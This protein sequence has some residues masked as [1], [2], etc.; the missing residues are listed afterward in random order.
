MA[1]KSVSVIFDEDLLEKVDEKRKEKKISRNW[2]ID[3]L[4][5]RWLKKGSK[6]IMED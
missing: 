3:Y 2:L 5:K 4:F 6:I 1:K